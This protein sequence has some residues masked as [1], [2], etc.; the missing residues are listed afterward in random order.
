MLCIRWL[1]LTSGS[2]I[3]YLLLCNLGKL[4]N[5][6]FPPFPHRS[7]ECKTPHRWAL[8]KIMPLKYVASYYYHCCLL[9]S[10]EFRLCVWSSLE[11]PGFLLNVLKALTV[12][13]HPYHVITNVI[14]IPRLLYSKGLSKLVKPV[15]FKMCA[16]KISV[17]QGSDGKQRSNQNGKDNWEFQDCHHHHQSPQP[18]SSHEHSFAFMVKNCLPSSV[19][20]C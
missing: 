14:K 19:K 12:W 18:T 7:Y 11:V 1:V 4:L 17:L 5:F 9:L 2:I 8:D 3:H 13:V 16:W 20:N 10:N 15:F 6:S